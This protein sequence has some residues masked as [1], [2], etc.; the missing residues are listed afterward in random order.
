MI[1]GAEADLG[2]KGVFSYAS[3]PQMT[4]YGYSF[5]AQRDE[6]C[7]CMGDGSHGHS[8]GESMAGNGGYYGSAS[9]VYNLGDEAV[10]EKRQGKRE[11]NGKGVAVYA[12]PRMNAE[13]PRFLD[14]ESE[15]ESKDEAESKENVLTKKKI[16]A[17]VP[18]QNQKLNDHQQRR[19]P[20]ATQLSVGIPPSNPLPEPNPNLSLPESLTPRRPT[21]ATQPPN[22][23]PYVFAQMKAKQAYVE[24]RE[25]L[26]KLAALKKLEVLK[27][28]EAF[29]KL[30]AKQKLKA[31]ALETEDF[32]RRGNRPNYYGDSYYSGG[33]DANPVMYTEES[34]G[35]PI[36]GPRLD[37][38]GSQIS[39]PV[40]TGK[41]SPTNQNL[42]VL[43]HEPDGYKRNKRFEAQ[44]DEQNHRTFE[45][46]RPEQYRELIKQQS[47]V[48]A[49][50]EHVLHTYHSAD[51]ATSTVNPNLSSP[52]WTLP[53][54]T[55]ANTA[56][57]SLASAKSVLTLQNH[58][59]QMDQ[60]HKTDMQ[61]LDIKYEVLIAQM[62]ALR[63]TETQRHAG[64]LQRLSGGMASMVGTHRALKDGYQTLKSDHE[65]Q[66]AEIKKLKGVM[67]G[68]KGDLN[69][70]MEGRKRE[71]NA[72]RRVVEEVREEIVKL[73]GL[74]LGQERG[75]IEQGKEIM[76][77]K[78]AAEEQREEMMFLKEA[79][80]AQGKEIGKLKGLVK[81]RGS[82]N[83]DQG[84]ELQALRELTRAEQESV[85]GV[86]KELGKEVIALW[87]P[88][89][90]E[91]EALRGVVGEQKEKI[92]ELRDMMRKEQM[93]WKAVDEGH[94]REIEELWEMIAS[95]ERE[96]SG[97]YEDIDG[98]EGEAGSEG[99]HE[100]EDGY[101]DRCE[102]GSWEDL[103]SDTSCAEQ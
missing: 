66:Q 18:E 71:V 20:K 19:L 91:Q 49:K 57:R 69:D 48:V 55:V 33:R 85:K 100:G 37:T 29:A 3:Q 89:N 44:R 82:D 95:H 86:V 68:L 6:Q 28:L 78:P 76:K 51:K 14:S 26:E 60:E 88:M 30:E 56:D 5:G 103:N 74:V 42:P 25:A 47:D 53:P 10:Q 67:E 9:N 61:K 98:D 81:Q 21:K 96:L 27:K 101:W 2:Q 64:Q 62:E 1:A 79:T 93:G 59:A 87:A 50:A 65:I 34:I 58:L 16:E 83:I 45:Q 84:L 90:A 8:F 15:R 24:R 17:K 41:A 46:Q 75:N 77:L 43:P 80:K 73:K 39:E 32:M 38:A 99:E 94:G 97:E 63:E 36:H 23:P 22:P 31:Q 54:P 40:S 70:D 92:E 11:G 12:G 52:N 35:V 4:G 13:S 7:E 102:G 72:L